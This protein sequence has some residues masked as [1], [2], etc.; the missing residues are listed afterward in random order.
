MGSAYAS[1]FG[2]EYLAQALECPCGLSCHS[3]SP[4]LMPFVTPPEKARQYHDYSRFTELLR[5]K[6]TDSEHS[7]LTRVALLS[8]KVL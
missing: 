8:P 3:S 1:P 4:S 5:R 2:S 7:S 6:A